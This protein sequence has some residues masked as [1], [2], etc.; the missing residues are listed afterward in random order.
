VY[1]GSV[2]VDPPVVLAPLAGITALPFRVQCRQAGAGL[3]CTE[4]VSANALVFGNPGALSLLRISAVEHPVSMQILAPTGEVAEEAAAASVEAGADIVDINM[5]CSVP[6][7]LKCHAGIDL[8]R[9]LG[10]AVEVMS[11]AMRGAAGRAPVTVKVRLGWSPDE[12]TVRDLGR[13]A[14]D[15]GIAAVTLH[16][17]FGVQHMGG[18]A[19]WSRIAQLKSDLSVP[20]IGNGDV[21]TAEDAV[22]MLR[23]TG[24]DAV[25]IGRAAMGN[26]W[27]FAQAAAAVR[28]EPVPPPPTHHERLTAMLQLGEALVDAEG[29]YLGVRQFRTHICH[30]TRGMPTSAAFRGRATLCPTWEQ[31]V[32][33]TSGYADS[34]GARLTKGA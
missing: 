7:V 11:G 24:C 2:R 34:I 28:G 14:Q 23:E 4:M 3:V 12:D 30:Y 22:R 29:E 13:R 15:A 19:D 31:V 27:L 20:V 6:K 8:M 25:M 32:A 17:R 33:E 21:R 16:A 5:G 1:I 9:D 26:P 18:P 10:R